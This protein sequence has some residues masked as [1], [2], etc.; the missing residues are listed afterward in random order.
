M[1]ISHTAKQVH[2]SKLF[3]L[4][5]HGSCMWTQHRLWIS[6]HSP[7]VPMANVGLGFIALVGNIM[8]YDMMEPRLLARLL[9]FSWPHSEE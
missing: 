9:L 4:L 2:I 8:T 7:S 5:H 3:T 1:E 6:A